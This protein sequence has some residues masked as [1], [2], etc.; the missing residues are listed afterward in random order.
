MPG[1]TL[2][3]GSI[4]QFQ[5]NIFG[6]AL[7]GPLKKDRI[8]L[9]G[10]FEGYEQHLGLSDVTLVPDNNARKGYLP[11]SDGTLHYVGVSPSVV[12]LLNLWPVQNGPEVGGGIAYAY[13]HP[14]QKIRE[15]FGTLRFDYNLS[16]KDS[17]YSVYTIDD[18]GANT[19]TANPLSLVDLTLREQVYSIQ[20]Q[21]V[22]SP[23]F[24]NTAR[25]GFSR[26]R[27]FF[28]GSTPVDV[29]GWVQGD[30]IGALVIGGGTALNGA[31]QITLAGTNAGSNLNAARNLYTFDDH[32]MLSRG[33]HQIEAGVLAA[34]YPGQRRPGAVSVWAG[35]FQQPGFVS[36]RQGFD[37]HGCPLP[38]PAELALVGDCRA[39]CRTSCD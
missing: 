38:Y 18:S 16:S 30:P 28:T 2:D 13:S 20:E 14:L 37:L 39:S 3:Q 8:F 5:R 29:P 4:P 19:P 26:A 11:A 10:N 15:D 6:G 36:A 9:F 23:S 25:F 1:T 35:V 32:F 12:P 33:V 27:F 31:S 21:H 22:I 34:A 7:G 17:L 24:L